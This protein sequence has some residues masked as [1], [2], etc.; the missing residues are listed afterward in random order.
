[1]YAL[2][3][4]EVSTPREIN[5]EFDFGDRDPERPVLAAPEV[6]L[7]EHALASAPSLLEPPE[8]PVVAPKIL[9]VSELTRRVRS[10]LEEQIGWVWVEG[11]VS[12][13]RRQSSGHSYFTLKDAGAQLS[14]VLFKN[15]LHAGM[16]KLDD[17]LCVHAFGEISVFEPQGKYQMI[18]REL[19]A[20]GEGVLQM[21]FEALKRKLSA[22]GLFDPARKKPLPAFAECVAIV[23]SPTGAALR[24][25]LNILGRRA[26]WLQVLIS[27]VRVQGDGAHG[28]IIA[29]IELLNDWRARG[30]PCP[31]VIVIARGGGSIEDLWNFNQESLARA[32]AASRIPVVS[33]IGHEIDFTIADFAADLRA[34]TPSAAAE[35]IV[36]DARTL[37]RRLDDLGVGMNGRIQRAVD[38]ARTVIDLLGRS[39][40]VREPYRMLAQ[41]SQRVDLL[42]DNVNSLITEAAR[43]A[44]QQVDQWESRLAARRPDRVL[45]QWTQSVVVLGTR[46]DAAARARLAS[47]HEQWTRFSA[48][49]KSLGPQSVFARGFSYTIG[50]DGRP[51]THARDVKKGERIRT[52]LA[53]GTIDSE[54]I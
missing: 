46:L 16:P 33:A 10:L 38:H 52:H 32:I 22:E 1:M 45:N 51:L 11:E 19:Q 6:T 28:E 39:G 20:A 25:M 35:L 41:H 2:T 31:D 49:M 18:V 29:A 17:G 24:D 27:P 5:L 42:A 4:S 53:V 47:S 12:N 48:L 30:L 40:L 14:C 23:T 34:S 37:C 7:A 3:A 8:E 26:P 13:V 54:V 50:P 21:R 43:R 9:T 44:A 15:S 36:P